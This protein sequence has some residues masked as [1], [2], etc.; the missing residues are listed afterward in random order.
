[1]TAY[2]LIAEECPAYKSM[3]QLCGGFT[4]LCSQAPEQLSH[5]PSVKEKGEKI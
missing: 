1:M 3:W 4:Q 5:S 2:V